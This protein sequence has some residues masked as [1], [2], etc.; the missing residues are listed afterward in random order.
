MPKTGLRGDD[1]WKRGDRVD[2]A[3]FDEPVL[4]EYNDADELLVNIDDVEDADRFVSGA[5]A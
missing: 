1:A 2:A 5:S 4:C 3:A